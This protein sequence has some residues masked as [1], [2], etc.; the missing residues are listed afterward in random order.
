MNSGRRP[1]STGE[2]INHTRLALQQV[3]IFAE[4]HLLGG[5]EQAERCLSEPKPK[6]PSRL[7]TQP[8]LH[9]HINEFAY[10]VSCR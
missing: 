10:P 7:I 9:C 2:E 6:S 4:L 1:S 5:A 8:M 3:Q